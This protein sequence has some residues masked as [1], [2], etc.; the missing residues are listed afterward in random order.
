MFRVHQTSYPIKTATFDAFVQCD[1]DGDFPEVSWSLNITCEPLVIDG[2]TW[3]PSLDIPEATLSI[4]DPLQLEFAEVAVKPA[5]DP[6]GDQVLYVPGPSYA[7][8]LKALFGERRGDR[9]D[10][11][12]TGDTYDETDFS[13]TKLRIMTPILFGG[14][15]IVGSSLKAA[16]QAVNQISD[17]TKYRYR[18]SENG[19]VF[20]LKSS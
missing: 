7:W 16:R 20:F 2:A 8:R 1:E 17:S 3:H 18:K 15:Y 14:I 12:L 6:D 4:D 11:L 13:D 19:F 5:N 9:F 10:L